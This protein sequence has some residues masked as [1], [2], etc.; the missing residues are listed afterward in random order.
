[1]KNLLR[2]IAFV[3]TVGNAYAQSK[4]QA[5]QGSASTAVKWLIRLLLLLL[6]L[7]AASQSHSCFAKYNSVSSCGLSV[8]PTSHW[9]L[10]LIA[11]RL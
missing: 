7:T 11:S 6:P 5:F 1:M 8:S 3:L 2:F 9:Y 10:P 4:L